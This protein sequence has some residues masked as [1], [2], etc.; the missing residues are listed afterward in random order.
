MIEP[1]LEAYGGKEKVISIITRLSKIIL[2]NNKNCL[3]CVLEKKYMFDEILE[4]EKTLMDYIFEQL[5]T[6]HLWMIQRMEQIIMG[7]KRYLTK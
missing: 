3:I 6:L 5:I 2:S 4:L 7:G 1:D